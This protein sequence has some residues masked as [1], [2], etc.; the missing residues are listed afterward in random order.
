M[1]VT[2][3]KLK[4]IKFWRY[5]FTLNGKR[6]RGWLEPVSTMS[7]RQALAEFQKIRANIVIEGTTQRKR[8]E[9]KALSK[10][11]FDEYKS[12]LKR[13]CSPSWSGCKYMFKHFEFFHR[14]RIT[15]LD[16]SIYQDLRRSQGVSNATINR[17][18][19]YC[20]AAFTRAVKNKLADRNPFIG[21]D[22]FPETKRTRYLSKDELRN[23][24]NA[25]KEIA[26]HKNPHIYEIVL[27]A[28][29]TGLRLQRIL[30][31]H[32]RQIDFDLELIRV[33]GTGTRKYKQTNAVPISPDLAKILKSKLKKSKSGFVFEDPYRARPYNGI[34]RSFQSA[35]KK[36]KI[37]DYR[38]HDLRHTF[39]TY[40]LLTGRD[41]RVVQTLMGHSNIHTTA[42]YTHI[43]TER[44]AEVTDLTSAFVFSLLDR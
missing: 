32:R 29:L 5:D 20:S 6:Y 23:L 36:A 1:K 16:I 42:R 37:A 3:R 19:A 27:T 9:G 2:A 12:Y 4:G 24:L 40:A 14:R 41:L 22:K 15:A 33:D 17:E 25:C 34:R 7:K 8:K 31:L 39:G 43:A 21:Y 18:L 28:I 13:H 30:K 38:F 10:Q 11:V 26:N 35:C 44:Q